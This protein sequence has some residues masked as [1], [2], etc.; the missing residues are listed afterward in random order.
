MCM[1]LKQEACFLLYNFL[2]AYVT[3][4]VF[5]FKL[6]VQEPDKVVE[7]SYTAQLS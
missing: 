6:L 7:L 4:V 3:Y 5:Y 1:Y 2:L